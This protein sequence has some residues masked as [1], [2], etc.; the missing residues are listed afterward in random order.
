[1]RKKSNNDMNRILVQHQVLKFC[2]DQM[3]KVFFLFLRIDLGSAHPI[4][5]VLQASG[6]HCNRSYF[7]ASSYLLSSVVY[8]LSS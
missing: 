2:E 3:D 7:N 6:Y 4:L 8:H 5:M 1:M